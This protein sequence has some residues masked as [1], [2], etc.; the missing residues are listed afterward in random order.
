MSYWQAI[1]LGIVQGFTEFL[2]ISSSGHLAVGQAILGKFDA[3]LPSPD[4]PTMIAFDLAVHL[5]TLIPIAIVFRREFARFLRGLRGG[6]PYAWRFLLLGVL[7]TAVSA[8]LVYPVKEAVER[9]FARPLAISCCW[10]VTAGVLI[11][12]ETRRCPKRGIRSF[13]W[14]MATGIGLVQAVATLPGVSRSGSTIAMAMILG[15]R[16]RWAVQFSF[17]LACPAILGASAGE[18]YRLHKLGY[19]PQW[20]VLGLGMIV[21]A[22]AGWLALLWLLAALKRTKLHYFGWYCVAIAA[23][24]IALVAV[25]VLQP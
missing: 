3:A 15:L 14:P 10:L 22:A 13:T 25:G 16:K 7:A 24:T 20:V 19:C 8:V 21:A 5:G 18:A 2:P 11:A 4:E 6:S 12:A 23:V 17:L 1:L 9:Q